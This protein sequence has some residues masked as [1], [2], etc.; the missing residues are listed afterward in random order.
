MGCKYIRMF[1]FRVKQGGDY[2]AYFPE[3]V[4]KLRGF[5]ERVKGKDVVLLHENEKRIYGDTPERCLQLYT[6]INDPQFKLAYD[7]SNFIQCGVNAPKAYEMLKDYV[8]YY[9]IKDC[10]PEKVEVPIGLGLGGYEEMIRDLVVNRHYDGFM[11]LEPH[12]GKYA[13]HKVLFHIFGWF[14]WML[15]YVGKWNKIF[16]R[17]DAAKN[18][19]PM[20]KVTRKDI[21]TWQYKGLKDILDRVEKENA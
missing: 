3:V 8:V 17:I 13:D 14:T 11:T 18:I 5:L 12:T 19:A 16:K 15:P 10:S 7:A 2:D 21:F 4:K 20:Q 1:S 6:E 9:H